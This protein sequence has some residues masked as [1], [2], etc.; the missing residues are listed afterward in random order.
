MYIIKLEIEESVVRPL[1]WRRE[2][3]FF[4]FKPK[5]QANKFKICIITQFVTLIHWVL[6]LVF[7]VYL[8]H[9]VIFWKWQTESF[10]YSI[11]QGFLLFFFYLSYSISL[12]LI[13]PY[14]LRLSRY[15]FLRYRTQTLN[16]LYSEKYYI[17]CI[18][19]LAPNTYRYCWRLSD[20]KSPQISN[21]FLR[22]V[23]KPSTS[24]VWT[25]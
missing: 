10:I 5:K 24:I 9:S 19:I 2:V 25:I 12:P 16:S 18:C 21:I 22:I 8:S 14:G 23:A 1:P 7:F 3:V 15:I 11:V 17:S 20:I 13:H 6:Y 4:L